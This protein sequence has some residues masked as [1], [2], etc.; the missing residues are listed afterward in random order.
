M[1][2]RKAT[3]T[4]KYMVLRCAQDDGVKQRQSN[5]NGKCDCCRW[6][7][8]ILHPTLRK[9]REGW[10]TRSFGTVWKEGEAKA[11][12]EILSCAQNDDVKTK[13]KATANANA[14]ATATATATAN[15]T[16][17]AGWGRFCIPPFAKSAK[18]G[19]P[20]IRDGWNEGEAKANT[21]SFPIRL[22][23]RS[24]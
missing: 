9:E 10:G 8:E 23:S 3:A 17:A 2:E 19:H 11:N 1:T 4:A 22:R 18:D 6:L 13:A 14:N 24:G 12:T 7:S 5:C 21:G 16:A 15:T 20:F